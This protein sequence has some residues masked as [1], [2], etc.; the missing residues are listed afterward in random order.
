MIKTIMPKV[1]VGDICMLRPP[2]AVKADTPLTFIVFAMN[3]MQVDAAAVI[4]EKKRCI[5][6]LSADDVM[7]H[8]SNMCVDDDT[9][10]A[11]DIMRTPN[12]AVCQDDSIE[13]V[14]M[15][16][17]AHKLE[18]LPVVTPKTKKFKGLVCRQDLGKVSTVIAFSK[19]KYMNKQIPLNAA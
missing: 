4:D 7:N 15:I 1:C 13:H 16:M 9:I 5:G 3:M 8:I 11:R 18:W 6:F 2:L 10:H 17:D 12:M 14:A 19:M